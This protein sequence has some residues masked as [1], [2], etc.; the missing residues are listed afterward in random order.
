M[1]RYLAR[2]FAAGWFCILAA[3]PASAA[4]PSPVQFLES[5][6]NIN[7]G[8][9][10]INSGTEN[11]G[12]VNEV[13]SLIESRL[14]ALGFTTRRIENPIKKSGFLLEGTYPA[15]NPG[16]KKIVTVITHA[17]TVFEPTS[18]FQ[19]FTVSSDG[20][21]AMGPGVGDDKAGLVIALDGLKR[22]LAKTPHPDFTIRFLSSPNE[23]TA[24][25]G[26]ENILAQYGKDSFIALGFES[27]N[28][29]G[30]IVD[31]RSGMVRYA[32]QVKGREAHSGSSHEEGAN[33]C[34]EL[35]IK[36]S[37]LRAL[38]SYAKGITVNTGFVTGGVPGKYNIVCG[39]A[40][41][42]VEMRFRTAKAMEE[43]IRESKKILE[44]TYVKAAKDSFPTTT[45]VTIDAKKNPFSVNEVSKPYV[46]RYVSI[47]KKL[48]TPSR[49]SVHI[50]GLADLNSMVHPGLIAMDDLGSIGGGA[51]TVQEYIDLPSLETR[52][53]ALKSFL[54]TLQK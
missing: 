32:I 28:P 51:H 42:K 14:K 19:R 17:D 33:A 23:E 46:E 41:A 24:S 12:G 50:N 30:S 44:T 35:A 29:D 7:S 2:G 10:N 47:L 21:R 20:A 25:P 43:G 15:G 31:G 49:K 52:T 22:F 40:E 48:E 36:I 5:L 16:S 4:E 9:E 8:T 45:T 26:F 39:A 6:V 18:P 53:E 54:E 11:I 38:G 27:T 13:Q 3:V 34:E 37:K 1:N